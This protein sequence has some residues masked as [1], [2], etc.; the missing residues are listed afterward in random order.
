VQYNAGGA[1]DQ[2]SATYAQ[3]QSSDG[4]TWSAQAAPE[5]T[6]NNGTFSTTYGDGGSAALSMNANNVTP[7]LVNYVHQNPQ[8]IEGLQNLANHN[9]LPGS[10]ELQ[11]GNG[12]G[13]QALADG[14][15]F[16][17]NNGS[18]WT[19]DAGQQA[20]QQQSPDTY[21]SAM[22]QMIDNQS[23][24]MSQQAAPDT[25][26]ASS[27]PQYA[28]ES[29]P[30]QQ[31]AERNDGSWVTQDSSHSVAHASDG[32]AMT[33]QP[34]PQ[35]P[36]S[37]PTSSHNPSIAATGFGAGSAALGAWGAL[38]KQNSMNNP[39]AAPKAPAQ[40][41]GPAAPEATAQNKS[42]TPQESQARAESEKKRREALAKLLKDQ[43][44]PGGGS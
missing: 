41:N 44:M 18:G 8:Q 9:Q 11:P 42:L 36:S 15:A 43:G 10:I 33:A 39:P 24:A 7:D 3:T 13:V 6:L 40:Q 38:K 26:G 5:L 21:M 29:S 17:Q 19:S 25:S 22:Q 1:Y 16:A 20:Q 4:G 37:P 35:M 14:Q 23:A 27:V 31:Y 30:P 2:S 12:G 32:H 34:E 28:P